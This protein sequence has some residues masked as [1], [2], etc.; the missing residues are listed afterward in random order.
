M[1]IFSSFF[2]FPNILSCKKDFSVWPSAATDT[3]SKQC[4]GPRNEIQQIQSKNVNLLIIS[5]RD[6]GFDLV[7]VQNHRAEA[8]LSEKDEINKKYIFLFFAFHQSF[9]RLSSR[10]V[11]PVQKIQNHFLPKV[12]PTKQLLHVHIRRHLLPLW[13]SFLLQVLRAKL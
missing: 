9:W 13:T 4:Q 6:G 2:S 5:K 7:F 12:D 10:R 11:E 3:A 1:M 8:Q